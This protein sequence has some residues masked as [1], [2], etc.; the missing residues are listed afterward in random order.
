MPEFDLAYAEYLA[1]KR[2]STFKSKL[3]K[4][5]K[6]YGE[7]EEQAFLFTSALLEVSMDI[8]RENGWFTKD[9]WDAHKVPMAKMFSDYYVASEKY[10]SIKTY[11][12]RS[13]FDDRRRQQIGANKKSSNP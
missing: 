5:H 10:A 4:A 1:R 6:K 7:S 9:S 3:L 8:C 11:Y 13:F 12:L 2:L